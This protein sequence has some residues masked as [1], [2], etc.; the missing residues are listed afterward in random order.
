VYGRYADWGFSQSPIFA[1]TAAARG[2]AAKTAR[3]AKTR[4]STSA[5]ATA[6]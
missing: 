1:L 6:A 5:S 2:A 3:A 4:E